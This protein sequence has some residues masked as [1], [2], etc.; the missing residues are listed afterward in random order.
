[1]TRGS[2]EKVRLKKSGSGISWAVVVDGELSPWSDG[3][4]G[5]GLYR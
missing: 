5:C 2:E 1:M 3:E 4:K